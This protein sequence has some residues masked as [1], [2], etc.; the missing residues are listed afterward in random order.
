MPIAASTSTA[1]QPSSSALPIAVAC[2]GILT[3]I[4]FGI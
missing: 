1:G 4:I 3:P 2:S